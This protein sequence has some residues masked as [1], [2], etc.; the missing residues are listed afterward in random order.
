MTVQDLCAV[1]KSVKARLTNAIGIGDI[2]KVLAFLRSKRTMT[3]K[4]CH[5]LLTPSKYSY[6]IYHNFLTSELGQ[7]LS[8]SSTLWTCC[9]TCGV[10]RQDIW[11]GI[12][13]RIYVIEGLQFF[14]DGYVRK[15]WLYQHP[16]SYLAV[17]SVYCHHSQVTRLWKSWYA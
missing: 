11:P 2:I 3:R 17:I 14:A 12:A 5:T 9:V 6:L 13:E 8:N 1:A 4:A 16:G 10:Q 7:S 15:M